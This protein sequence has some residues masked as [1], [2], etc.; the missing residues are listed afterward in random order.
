MGQPA[1]WTARAI[2]QSVMF[3]PRAERTLP[4]PLDACV[5]ATARPAMPST[6]RELAIREALSVALAEWIEGDWSLGSAWSAARGPTRTTTATTS[7]G[8]ARVTLTVVTLAERATFMPLVTA[9]SLLR[10]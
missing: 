10:T 6:A 2:G 3:S 7:E 1:Q 5:A 4:G 8:A 9:P